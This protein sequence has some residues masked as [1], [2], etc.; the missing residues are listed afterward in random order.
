MTVIG[1]LVSALAIWRLTHLIS[2]EDGPWDIIARI[3]RT[4]GPG[5]LGQAMDC[6]Y[7]L[8][9]WIAVPFACWAGTT[10]KERA[11]LWPAL[12]GAAILLERFSAREKI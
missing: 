1:I 12:S 2:E 8:S 5:W 3:R 4:V 6:F 11:V 10:W 9:L 7:C